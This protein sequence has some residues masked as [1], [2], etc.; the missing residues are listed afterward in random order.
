MSAAASIEGP[1]FSP[2]VWAML[3]SKGLEMRYLSESNLEAAVDIETASYPE[4]EAASPENMRFRRANAG[5]FFLEA[6]L[7]ES[8]GGGE[9]GELA[10]FVCG[11]LS[12]GEE[13]SHESMHLHDPDGATLCIHSVAVAE[14]FRRRGFATSMLKAYV[15]NVALTQLGVRR[16]CLIAKAGLLGMYAS[17]GF[18]LKGLS[19]VVH[20]KDPW[21]EMRTEL[22]STEPRLLRF[23]QV[24]AFSETKF[25]GNPAA[26]FFTQAG[27]DAVWMQKVAIEMNLSET[28]FLD[29]KGPASGDQ[30]AAAAARVTPSSDVGPE[31]ALRWFTPG[32]EVDLC[33]HAT[34]AAA[35]ALWEEGRV[36]PGLPVRFSTASGVLTCRRDGEGWVAMDFPA[37]FVGDALPEEDASRTAIV[38]A[39]GLAAGGGEALFVGRNRFDVMVEV[40]PEA[41]ARLD[42]DMRLLA[43]VE[44]RGSIVTCKA[45]QGVG[46]SSAARGGA[47]GGGVVDF[48]S[49]FFAPRMGIDE[50]PVTGS[51]H[52]CLAPYWA[53]KLDKES[54]V[55]YQASARGGTV[56]ATMAKKE[57]ADR[58][59]LEGKAVTVFRGLFR[60]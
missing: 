36:D 40:T 42:P 14:K 4:D 21:F 13:L 33:G 52:C 6:T 58:V 2:E 25:G 45:G 24:D 54:V 15:E 12:Q 7:K 27:G 32:G 30:A 9:A 53:A 44:S 35:F 48:Q 51:A 11:T 41:F 57:G 46:G 34:L 59:V 38:Q 49:R 47:E 31:Y 28:C 22:D 37:E 19:P 10:G 60:R 20:G 17:A 56:R 1:T 29:L 50:D 8:G 3:D 5:A 39:L 16:I 43:E 23:V 26:V 18:S 55:G